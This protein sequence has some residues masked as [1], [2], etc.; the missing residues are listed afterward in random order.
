MNFNLKKTWISL[1]LAT[2]ISG[3]ISAILFVFIVD[4]F[5]IQNSIF[6]SLS[7]FISLST[8][9][10]YYIIS[11]NFIDINEKDKTFIISDK[12]NILLQLTS[13]QIFCYKEPIFNSYK[14]KNVIFYFHIII[15]FILSISY[16]TL[17]HTINPDDHIFYTIIYSIFTFLIILI[18]YEFYILQ[19]LETILKIF[20]SPFCYLA[21]KT[22]YENNT[23]Y[24]N[25][26]KNALIYKNNI[27]HCEYLP[28]YSSHFLPISFIKCYSSEIKSALDNMSIEHIENT[29]ENSNIKQ[30]WYLNGKKIRNINTN[31]SLKKIRQ[32]LK[33]MNITNNF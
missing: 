7:L 3:L 17:F 8:N 29:F 16:F 13:E 24:I 15:F 9:L 11:Y 32:T 26:N 14:I 23:L 31:N 22:I 30:T 25:E 33:T 2:L 6:L 10:R 18:L 12:F 21:K 1:F 19:L 5:E 4:S 28:A 27:L 20:I